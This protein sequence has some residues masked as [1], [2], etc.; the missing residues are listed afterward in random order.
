MS[1]PLELVIPILQ[2]LPQRHLLTTALVSHD[3]SQLSLTSFYD[4]VYIHTNHQ[5]KRFFEALRSLPLVYR[6]C[7]RA[8]YFNVFPWYIRADCVMNHPIE[9]LPIYCPQ[10]QSLAVVHL[11]N[12]VLPDSFAMVDVQGVHYSSDIGIHIISNDLPLCPN[13]RCIGTLLG[14]ESL[15]KYRPIF[16]QLTAMSLEEK[17]LFDLLDQIPITEPPSHVLFPALHTLDLTCSSDDDIFL[18][19]AALDWLQYHCPSLS[20]LSLQ[21]F[22]FNMIEVPTQLP[23]HASLV[24]LDLKNVTIENR[25]WFYVFAALYPALRS[26][27]LDVHFLDS[28][29]LALLTDEEDLDERVRRH[30]YGMTYEILHWIVRCASLRSLVIAKLGQDSVAHDLLGMLAGMALDSSWDCR[31]TCIAIGECSKESFQIVKELL[32]CQPLTKHL[33]TLCLPLDTTDNDDRATVNGCAFVRPP[34]FP[35]CDLAPDSLA[36][37]SSLHLHQ[38]FGGTTVAL[39]QLLQTCTNLDTLT[40]RNVAL[41]HDPCPLH[42]PS[43]ASSELLTKFNLTSL[44]LHGCVVYRA[45]LFYALLQHQL[46]QLSSLAMVNVKLLQL[47]PDPFLNLDVALRNLY[48]VWVSTEAG[49][50]YTLHLYENQSSTRMTRYTCQADDIH[51]RFPDTPVLHIGCRYADRVFFN[52]NKGMND[53]W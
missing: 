8:I 45:D 3:W 24:S 4:S 20:H 15:K 12:P 49:R 22:S 5:G 14:S 37:I 52:R 50:C 10:L 34:T 43:L 38:G 36:N 23:V 27:A 33:N 42:F 28:I 31:L 6:Q 17:Q 11:D 26:L 9:L 46:P 1:L 47:G 53:S 7:I 13:M 19:V 16:Q 39:V 21:G 40:L 25:H 41:E 35:P 18:G 44:A 51:R 30:R 2:Q 29:Q 32:G 48:I